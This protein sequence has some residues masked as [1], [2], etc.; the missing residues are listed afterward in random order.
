MLAAHTGRQ[1]ENRRVLAAF[2]GEDLGASLAEDSAGRL[3]CSLGFGPLAVWDG[4]SLARL[5]NPGAVARH[6]AV[7]AG[8][9]YAVN[10]DFSLSIWDSPGQPPWRMYLFLD[11]DWALL[12]PQGQ[13]YGSPGARRH[14]AGQGARA[15]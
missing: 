8:R 9:L 5:D 12:G 13:V 6:L 14:L 11:G 10:M 7:H 3:Y 2:A 1:L 15:R 4:T